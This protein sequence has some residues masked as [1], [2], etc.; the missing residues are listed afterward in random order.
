VPLA[1]F[2]ALAEVPR[3]RLVSVQHGPG[4]EQLA[5]LRDRF[6]VTQLGN[7][8]GSGG[9][10]ADTAAVMASLDLVVSVDTATGHLAGALGLPVWVPLPTLVDW[11]WLLGRDDSPWYPTMRLFRQKALGDWEPVFDRM[12]AELRKRASLVP[13]SMQPA[14]QQ[15]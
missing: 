1:L 12:A 13:K 10:L 11:R 14:Q 2:A 4:S 3:V 7:E 8:F 9:A 5:A 6:P 15:K